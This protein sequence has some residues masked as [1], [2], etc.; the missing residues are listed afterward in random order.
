MAVLT[1]KPGAFAIINR[2]WRYI[3]YADNTEELYDVEADPNEW[4]NLAG[5]PA[6]GATKMRLGKSAPRTFAEPGPLVNGR[7]HLVLEGERFRWDANRKPTAK[8]RRKAK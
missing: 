1:L 4:T 2:D 3:H 5:N 7:W 8:P 6:F